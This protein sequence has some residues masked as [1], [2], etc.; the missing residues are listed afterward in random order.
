MKVIRLQSENVM[1]LVAVDITP[2]GNLITIGGKNG[3]GKT[4][5]LNSIAMALGGAALVPDEPI[6]TGESA[7]KIEVDLGDYKVTRSFTRI[8]LDDGTWG[9]TE[10]KL[11]VANVHGAPYP[12]PQTLLNKILGKLTFDPLAFAN[13]DEKPQ[14]DMLRALVN[15]DVSAI[16]QKRQN[17]YAQR[18]ILNK[19][20]DIKSA[21]LMKLVTHKGAPAQEIPQD[22]VIAELAAAE[23]KQ[24]AATKAESDYTSE[25]R[26]RDARNTD[27]RV[28]QDRIKHLEE[29]LTRQRETETAIVSDLNARELKIAAADERRKLAA[30]EVPDMA[31]LRVK[32][33]HIATVNAQVRDNLKY[34]EAAAEV[35]RIGF[36]AKAQD[37]IVKDCEDAKRTALEAVT[38]PVAGLGLSETGVTFNG[39]PFKQASA[40]EQIRVSVAIGL[41]MNPTLKVLLIRN[42]NVLDEDSLQM[43]AKQ[44]E[45]AQAQVW[46]EYVTKNADDVSVLIEDGHGTLAPAGPAPKTQTVGTALKNEIDLPFQLG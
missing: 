8:K 4:S 30:S 17:A 32:L 22:E 27:L 23:A 7:A 31:A 18:S 42:G 2:D 25:V 10:S 15:L 38:F 13:A 16:E 9:P 1:R 6:R 41:A 34:Q 35:D 29:E 21:Q 46:M 12:S 36:D 45:D 40:A 44:A 43:V 37:Q 28:V 24:T 39:L 3:A 26:N 19:T 33:T 20:H 11:I 5:V 14:Y